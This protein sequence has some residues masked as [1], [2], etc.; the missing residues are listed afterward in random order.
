MAGGLSPREPSGF[1]LSLDSAGPPSLYSAGIMTLRTLTNLGRPPQASLVLA[2]LACSCCGTAAGPCSRAPALSQPRPPQA[3]P[4]SFARLGASP[5]KASQAPLRPV[6]RA[7]A[8]AGCASAHQGYSFWQASR[9][10]HSEPRDPV[11]AQ[12]E[13]HCFRLSGR[14][15]DC[16][17][18]TAGRYLIMCEPLHTTAKFFIARELIRPASSGHASSKEVL[19]FRGEGAFVSVALPQDDGW[20]G[21]CVYNKW[22]KLDRSEW[23]KTEVFIGRQT[24][25]IW[26]DGSPD[27]RAGACQ[28]CLNWS[29][30][31]ASPLPQAGVLGRV[32]ELPPSAPRVCVKLKPITGSSS[33]GAD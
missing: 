31:P 30:L 18:R 10:L 28:A 5:D 6:L 3:C 11:L 25:C 1:Q 29:D 14:R 33:A 9:V 12:L 8:A 2:L 16:I 22:L 20:T 23:I 19:S 24:C 26:L 15:T 4:V 32:V 7:M 27:R 21:K 17:F 13:P